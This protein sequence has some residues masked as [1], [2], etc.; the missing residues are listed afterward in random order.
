[1]P[2]ASLVHPRVV[3]FSVTARKVQTSSVQV[4][5]CQPGIK[6]RGKDTTHPGRP[7]GIIEVFSEGVYKTRMVSQS[8]LLPSHST[9]LQLQIT[10]SFQ[11]SNPEGVMPRE[12]TPF[13]HSL[14]AGLG[15]V[16]PVCGEL[17]SGEVE[18]SPQEVQPLS[19][20][21]FNLVIS[22]VRKLRSPANPSSKGPQSPSRSLSARSQK[23]NQ[24]HPQLLIVRPETV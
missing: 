18:G 19:W 6:R 1:M 21:L 9:K 3:V 7:A 22:V 24:A 8:H 16:D 15:V 12:A 20:I 11:V 17:L 13:C 23:T 5:I 4:R 2:S 10:H 14:C